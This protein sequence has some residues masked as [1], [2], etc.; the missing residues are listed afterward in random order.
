MLPSRVGFCMDSL[1]DR[2]ETMSAILP[3]YAELHCLSNFTFLTGAS[4]PEELVERAFNLGYA[5][6]AMT[7]ECSL[8][9]VVRAH[10][11]AKKHGLHLILG[12]EMTLACGLKLV[13]L[14]MNREGYGNLAEWI[15]L[16]RCRAPKGRY[17]VR[18]ADIGAPLTPGEP[19]GPAH[20]RGLP[21]CIALFVPDHHAGDA[22]LNAQAAW[23]AATFPQRAW[24]ALELLHRLD[25][26]CR[27]ERLTALSQRHAL[28][29]V[30]SGDVHMHVRSRKPLQDTLTAIRLGKPL[31]ECGLALQANAEQHLRQRVRLAQIYPPECLRQTRIIASHCRFSLEE[32]RYQYPEEIVPAGESL[33]GYLRRLTY[34]GAVTRFPLGIPASVQE[35]VERELELIA[36]LSYEPYFLT[37]HDIVRFARSQRILCQGRGSAA[38]SAVCYCLG[39]T[40]VDPA[41]MTVLFERFI[42]KER[43]EPPDID[44]DFEHERREEVIQYIYRKYGRHRAALTAALITY[45]PRSALK[46]VGKALGM[47][48][49]SLNR[50]SKLHHWW[51][52]RT[53]SAERLQENGV[54]PES[55]VVQ[56]L[57]ALSQT[58][59]GFPRHL[60]QHSGGFVIARDSLARLVP[61]EN[62]AMAERNVIQWDKD[63][64]DAMGLLKIDVLALGMLSA[65]RRALDLIGLRRGELFTMQD[66]PAEDAATY[67]MIAKADTV[68]VFQ[69]ESRAQ[70]SMLPRLK[71]DKFYDLVIEVAIVRPGPIQGGM[72]HPYLKRKQ[73]LEAVDY[74]SPAVQQ[75]LERTLGIPIFQEQVMQIAMVAAGFSG[76]EADSLRRAMA[77]WKRKGGVEKFYDRIVG[78]M[79][80]RGYEQSFAERI[81]RQIEGFGEYGFPESHAASF[82]LLVYISAWIKRHEPAAFLAALLNAQPMGFYSASQLV[83]DARRH[84]VEVRPPDIAISEWDC[85][86]EEAPDGSGQPAVRLGLR[87]LKGLAGGA[88]E[89]IADARAMQPFDSIDDLKRRAELSQQDLQALARANALSSLSGHRRQVAWQV[90]GMQTMPGLLKDASI[91]EEAIVLP[92]ASEGQEILADYASAGLTLNRHPLA[93]LRQQLKKMNLSTA[94]EMQSFPNR[95]L[96][97]TTGLVTMRQRPQTA[98]GTLFVTLEDETGNINVIVWPA[99][100][101]KQRKEILNA[102]LMTVYGVWQRE[103]EVVH[104]I[105]KRVV[106]HSAMLGSLMVEGRDFY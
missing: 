69:I 99:L 43:N 103:G 19:S 88:V 49:D 40:E 86:L 5:S 100:L 82:A 75:V 30:A 96:A 64:L 18:R 71:P 12:S 13:L 4:H 80:E 106:D 65:I 52:G 95:K 101:E 97:R 81:F 68:G 70:M 67:R 72:V 1:V 14:A 16:G 54:D 41:R 56:K 85:T 44:V 90:A 39:I 28:P 46:D 26:D 34:D 62:A 33:S 47:D 89:R 98:K 20:L 61:I 22:L 15:T 93:L 25:D 74:P 92:P 2:G 9:G 8:A 78:G 63:D 50:L 104:L 84:Q 51:D 11:E 94:L 87:L 3:A 58:L 55:P 76:G 77:A 60:S 29:L 7:D 31:N 24:I 66:V 35:L 37:V 42:S 27:L 59:I 38:N 23:V 79:L 57:L 83:Q 53:I 105:A 32:L 10:V 91:A 36:D 21:D 17:D 6:L 48:Y 45:R 73:G 102:R